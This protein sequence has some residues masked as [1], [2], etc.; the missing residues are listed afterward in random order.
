MTARGAAFFQYI[1]ILRG[2]APEQSP[3]FSDFINAIDESPISDEFDHDDDIET[4]RN[5]SREKYA[6][7]LFH[8]MEEI[9]SAVSCLSW[10]EESILCIKNDAEFR[11]RIATIIRYMRFVRFHLEQNPVVAQI[12]QTIRH[13]SDEML[14]QDR[15]IARSAIGDD[16]AMTL[17]IAL[18]QMLN[19]IP[20]LHCNR[21]FP[22]LLKERKR[23]NN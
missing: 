15:R 7:I 2:G 18:E 13:P 6:K 5:L 8:Q 11:E 14:P 3:A 1:R 16:E 21:E 9:I 19:R 12:L 23:W 10:K 4:S 22:A 17:L 20:G